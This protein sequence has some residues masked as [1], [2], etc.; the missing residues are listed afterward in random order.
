MSIVI[1]F[2]SKKKEYKCLSNFWEC[3]IIIQQDSIEREYNSGELC[4]HGEKFIR[5]SKNCSDV[6]RKK[7]LYE[8]GMRF[9]DGGDI[10]N[11]KDAK[12]KGG[13][14]KNGFRLNE[15]ELRDWCSI[16]EEVQYEICKYKLENYVEVREYLEKSK[17]CLL[18][19][20]IGMIGNEKMKERIWEGRIVKKED[21]SFEIL[22]GNKLGNIWMR[23]R[24][25]IM[26]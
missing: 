2:C 8:Y 10:L 1:T 26:L 3:K 14:G 22:G 20:S 7:K 5:L 21:G 11:S 15:G 19:H 4:F 17:G 25:G 9:V 13:K 24:D 23:I 16:S 6:E 12:S 18:I